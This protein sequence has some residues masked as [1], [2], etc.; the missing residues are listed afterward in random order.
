MSKK[1][2]KKKKKTLT[3]KQRLIMSILPIG[4][5]IL[6]G[7]GYVVYA[8]MTDQDNVINDFKI[9][10][11]GGTIKEEF[12]PPSTSNPFKPGTAYPK[13]V[14]VTNTNQ[15]PFF[16]RV[17]VTPEIT[18]NDGILLA[19]QIGKQLTIDL[20]SDWILGEDGFYYYLGKVMPNSSTTPVFTKV[21][22]ASNVGKEYD[23]ATFTLN[24][25]SETVV[26]DKDSYRQ[27]WWQSKDTPT[28]DNL[29]KVDDSLQKE[30]Q[31]D[32]GV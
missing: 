16:V 15:T 32:G 25:K 23:G 7:M 29:K 30:V 26:V 1:K 5:M 24:I 27:A 22:L 20:G 8:A 12:T 14:Q 13:K 3:K 4:L 18:S 21:T 31:K 11:E 2:S 19:S 17:S 28:Q 6:I 10:N 9:A